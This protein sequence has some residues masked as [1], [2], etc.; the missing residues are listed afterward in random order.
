MR[1]WLQSIK[2]RF[3]RLRADESGQSALFAILTLLLLMIVLAYAYN[4]GLT[5]SHRVRMQNAAD[6]A[7]YSAAVVEANGLSSIAWLN[8]CQTYIHSKLQEQMLDLGV[9]TLAAATVRWGEYTKN[10]SA[11]NM[12]DRFT[13]HKTCVI[14]YFMPLPKRGP[15]EF[16]GR[17]EDIPD[18]P[19]AVNGDPPAAELN[20]AFDNTLYSRL[21][22]RYGLTVSDGAGILNAFMNTIK[23]DITTWIAD[24]ETRTR[25]GETW[26]RQLSLVA[27]AVATSLPDMM[28]NEAV[29]QIAF[30]APSATRMT[31]FPDV[32]QAGPGL[33]FDGT[34]SLAGSDAGAPEAF[35]RYDAFEK[36]PS[37]WVSES[38]QNNPVTWQKNGFLYGNR[39]LSESRRQAAQQGMLYATP[40]MPYSPMLPKYAAWFDEYAG[41]PGNGGTGLWKAIMCWNR[42]DR[43]WADGTTEASRCCVGYVR[44]TDYDKD[45][46]QYQKTSN[47]AA[48]GHWHC[49]HYH[50]HSKNCHWSPWG[51][52]TGW[53]S[54]NCWL[55]G[56]INAFANPPSC[57]SSTNH[58]EYDHIDGDLHDDT[59][60]AAT[61]D[62][63]NAVNAHFFC[64]VT[65]GMP[66]L[67]P[68]ISN[69]RNCFNCDTVTVPTPFIT[70]RFCICGKCFTEAK[71]HSKGCSALGRLWE[72]LPWYNKPG[73]Q[74]YPGHFYT[75]A[76]WETLLSGDHYFYQDLLDNL[77]DFI[78]ELWNNVLPN[79]L[80]IIKGNT[81][82]MDSL[83]DKLAALQQTIN[84]RGHHMF[85]VCPLC[86]K[87]CPI[88]NAMHWGADKSKPKNK[89]S[90]VGMT[91]KQVLAGH[92]K[93]T[94]S[95]YHDY[96]LGWDIDDG[97]LGNSPLNGDPKYLP[98]A[99][100]R[101]WRENFA[102]DRFV[103]EW[104]APR[105]ANGQPHTELAPTV[106]AT[107]N[108]FRYGV[109][110]ALWSPHET[111]FF[112]KFLGHR[113]GHIALATARVGFIERG[114]DGYGAG[115]PPQIITGAGELRKD[116]T[117]WTLDDIWDDFLDF[118]NT[119]SGATGNLYYANWG[120]KL[121][122]TQY[123]ILPNN[124]TRLNA[125]SPRRNL[126]Q[127][128]NGKTLWFDSLA[129]GEK[130]FWTMLGDMPC[131][132]GNGQMTG[133]IFGNLVIPGGGDT[134][135]KFVDAYLTSRDA[136]E[137]ITSE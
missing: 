36:A 129:S 112:G 48:D 44:R 20:A 131:Y 59:E 56:L 108:L 122:S 50:G 80:N 42:L 107:E 40:N 96:D 72:Y 85:L 26:I 21:L 118:P 6:A 115:S 31:F 123:A 88:C 66:D 82:F 110:V 41:C 30:N 74:S 87:K 99:P 130:A 127:T 134:W 28:R 86:A 132:N 54:F 33:A 47:D 133:E 17:F 5:V 81:D 2:K 77:Q 103:R 9:Y 137:V 71:Y 15:P 111:L 109:T 124:A 125:S 53:T 106:V 91:Y 104:S 25:R 39:F 113:S 128:A 1:E 22:D 120:A 45:Q 69:I 34:P 52:C 57:F 78:D 102:A 79:L 76:D 46:E 121:V 94:L 16:F 4:V 89:R 58:E 93:T 7:A 51:F 73:Y 84:R 24:R 14:P 10:A 19:G 114:A 38:E 75:Y 13:V 65:K 98:L 62:D 101:A 8:S 3:Y 11:N 67:L 117:P 92:D 64:G 83:K 49:R 126:T 136:A 35:F 27:A 29:Y 105:D 61:D 43:F 119:K 12:A 70:L 95:S 135:P 68:G 63:G 100:N 37:T 90:D 55:V 18:L 60:K 23:P 32:T 116:G 97:L